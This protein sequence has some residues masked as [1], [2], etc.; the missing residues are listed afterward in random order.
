M[1]CRDLAADLERWLDGELTADRADAYRRHVATC[2]DCRA[3]VDRRRQ[4]RQRWRA[5]LSEPA[6]ADLRQAVLA[7][8]PAAR[9]LPRWPLLAAAAALLAL[10]VTPRLLVEPSRAEAPFSR[11]CDLQH[12]DAGAGDQ[13]TLVLPGGLL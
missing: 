10:L 5:A 6:P 4:E 11:P 7:A 13:T 9:R 1:L 3:R 8:R 12:L 2:A